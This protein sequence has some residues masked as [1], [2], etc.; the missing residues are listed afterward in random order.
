MSSLILYGFL[1]GVNLIIGTLCMFDYMKYKRKNQLVISILNF[2]SVFLVLFLNV[3]P[4]L[5]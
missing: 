2:V 4:V 3:M 5:A 1:M